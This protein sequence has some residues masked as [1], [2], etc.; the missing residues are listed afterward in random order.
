MT[1]SIPRITLIFFSVTLLSA[2]CKQANPAKIFF[3]TSSTRF[4][5][6]A[7]CA[8]LGN[9]CI[10]LGKSEL[11]EYETRLRTSFASDMNCQGVSL[12][13]SAS[14]YLKRETLSKDVEWRLE[15]AWLPPLADLD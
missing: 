9:S 1:K 2:G 14:T 7:A 4:T 6:N 15:I 5:M 13:G 12:V 11:S 10:G 3:D 8:N